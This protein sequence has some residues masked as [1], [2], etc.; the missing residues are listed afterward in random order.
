MHL[1]N[2]QKNNQPLAGVKCM[3]NTC[4]FYGQGDHCLAANIEVAP[5]NA[6][7]TQETDCNTFQPKG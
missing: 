2:T 3:V 6:Q 7:S 5:Q 4:H 1:D